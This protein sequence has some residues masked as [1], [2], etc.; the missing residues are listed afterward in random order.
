MCIARAPRVQLGRIL[1]LQPTSRAGGSGVQSGGGRDN[2]VP[3]ELALGH[4][5][6]ATM[7][8]ENIFLFV[9][10]LIGECCP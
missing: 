10:N 8:E 2:A 1:L 6:T 4:E 5:G 9:P 3:P 7:A